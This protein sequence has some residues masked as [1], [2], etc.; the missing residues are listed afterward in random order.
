MRWLGKPTLLATLLLLFGIGIAIWLVIHWS[1]RPVVRTSA[2]LALRAAGV[3][4]VCMAV[5]SGSLCFGV[6]VDYNTTVR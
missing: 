2:A 4:W 5:S 1:L 3:V 6:L